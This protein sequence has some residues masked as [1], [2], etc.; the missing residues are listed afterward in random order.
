GAAT[1]LPSDGLHP[2]HVGHETGVPT[3]WAAPLQ[4]SFDVHRLPSSQGRVFGVP[5]QEPPWQVSFEVQTLPSSQRRVFGVPRHDPP[6]QVS[7]DVHTLPSSHGSLLAGCVQWPP[8]SQTSSRQGLP[9]SVHAEPWGAA[10]HV[11]E[12]HASPIVSPSSQVSPGDT[13][14]LPQA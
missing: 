13:T 9:S 1:Q 8:P 4:V 6:W 12:Q 3:H 2:S 14:P 7:F 10:W 11:E 5:R